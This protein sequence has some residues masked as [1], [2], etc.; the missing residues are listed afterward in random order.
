MRS[1]V[2]NNSFLGPGYPAGFL[3]GAPNY[4]VPYRRWD[5]PRF[6][7]HSALDEVLIYPQ[8]PTRTVSFGLHVLPRVDF[9]SEK[10]LTGHVFQ[11]WDRVGE[12]V[13]IKEVYEGDLS[14]QLSFF[15]TLYRF[16]AELLGP[17][18]Y[19]A[20]RPFDLTDRM[21]AVVIT[22]ITLD[23]EELTPLIVGRTSPDKWMQ[24]KLEVTLKLLPR[25]IPAA[26]LFASGAFGATTATG[27]ATA[28][29]TGVT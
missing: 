27:T 6:L 17:D 18:D 10:T 4:W 1:P 16:W 26:T 19:C 5:F 23:A 3:T 20:W 28:T 15:H 25:P 14:Q 11:Q 22:S 2:L 21:Y 8:I 29:G 7:Y 9:I 12:D 13:E 24:A